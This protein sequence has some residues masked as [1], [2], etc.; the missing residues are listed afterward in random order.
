[1]EKVA[2]EFLSKM[3]V[4]ISK[5]YV[6]QLILGHPDYPSMLS[7]SDVFTRLGVNHRVTRIEKD[8]LSEVEYPYL[9][10]LDKGRGDVLLIDSHDSL[11]KNNNLLE[12]WSGVILV[13]ESLKTTLDSDNNHL[14]RLVRNSKAYA[15]L[16]GIA[17]FILLGLSQLS[18]FSGFNFAILFLAL[19]GLV[20]G[21]FLLA[22]ELGIAYAAVEAF[23]NTGKNTNCDV[24]LKSEVSLLGIKFSDA[25]VTYFLFQ[26]VIIG[27]AP[28]FDSQGLVF[29]VMATLSLL[30]L[31]IICFSLYYQ[32]AV[33]KTW[34][35]LCLVVVA[36]LT[37][38]AVIFGYALSTGLISIKTPN[39]VNILAIVL[40]GLVLLATVL[41]IKSTI[42]THEKLNQI[43]GNGNRVKHNAAIFL[44]F[45]KK[46]K[47]IDDAPFENEMVIGNPDAP[48]KITVASNLFCNPCKV[49]HEVG[50]QL[51]AM[52]PESIQIA[53][54]FVKSGKDPDSVKHLLNFWHQE[55]KGTENESG[56]TTKLMHDWFAIWDFQKFKEK[57]PVA[58]NKPEVDD[59]EALHYGWMNDSGIMQ[60]PTFV[61][62]GFEL[63]K[64]YGIEDLLAMV[65]ALNNMKKIDTKITSAAN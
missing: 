30:T 39:P 4:P 34:C 38:Q 3:K 16:A 29:Q 60:T 17:I 43:M 13:A 22:K 2:V 19:G 50:A 44:S 14:H 51:V 57:F 31:P 47:Q 33:A 54:R 45:L 5:R 62:N 6:E 18:S 48:L 53:I 11:R 65:P 15:L 36:L 37:G 55:I 61:V 21:Y 56:N 20:T 8:R 40:V 7:V 35:R 25:A 28:L 64:E 42:E 49:K 32:Y 46:Q 52:Y 1:M 24:V 26:A 41:L 23:C 63:P 59:L 12:E 27:F 10:P 58:V 9:L